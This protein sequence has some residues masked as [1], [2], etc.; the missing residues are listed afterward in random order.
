MMQWLFKPIYGSPL[1]PLDLVVNDKYSEIQVN[2]NAKK[3][4]GGWQVIVK[5]GSFFM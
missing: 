5:H 4:N 1:G 3:T 2:I